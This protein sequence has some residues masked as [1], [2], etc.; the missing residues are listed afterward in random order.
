MVRQDHV[1]RADERVLFLETKLERARAAAVE[2]SDQAKARLEAAQRDAAVELAAV[3]A[4]L[5]AAEDRFLDMR[6]ERARTTRALQRM[7][8]SGGSVSAGT[9]SPTTASVLS[10]TAPP[11]PAQPPKRVRTRSRKKTE[12]AVD[13][14]HPGPSR[15]GVRLRP[16]G[17]SAKR[18]V[19]V[20]QAPSRV[21]PSGAE[22]V[23]TRAGVLSLHRRH[24]AVSVCRV[25][26][27]GFFD[28][29]LCAV[30]VW[31]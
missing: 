22:N 13:G 31:R 7:S 18:K 10:T 28:L 27:G 12:S 17:G 1:T 4:K 26:H 21:G 29:F 6:R 3:Q 30:V 15:F 11:K 20:H 8:V 2:A 23:P 5:E 16:A 25:L 14:D 24:R 9:S 19:A